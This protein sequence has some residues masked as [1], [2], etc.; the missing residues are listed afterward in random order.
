MI[1]ATVSIDSMRPA[2][3]PDSAIAAFMSPPK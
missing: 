1:L 2:T 3:W